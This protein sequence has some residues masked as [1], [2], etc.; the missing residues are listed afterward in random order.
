MAGPAGSALPPT[1][2]NEDGMWWRRHDK[3]DHQ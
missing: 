1:R 2:R 3:Y